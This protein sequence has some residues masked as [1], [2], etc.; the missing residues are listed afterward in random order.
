M[1]N[2]NVGYLLLGISILIIFIIFIFNNA[3]K[4]FGEKNCALIQEGLFCPTHSAVNQQTYLSLVVV[5]LLVLVA[6]FLIFSKP[7]ERIIIRKV[8][9]R[10]VKIDTSEL[11][12]EEK[13]ILS[14]IQEN[15]A[16]FQADLIEKT[17]YGKAKMTRILDRLEG[18]GFVERKRRGMTNVVVLK[19]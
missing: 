4:E 3:I 9:K 6:L 17:G 2:K 5:G 18:K 19:E 16:V 7:Q 13:K 15:K 11:K 12:S 8:G 10:R 1:E 14:L